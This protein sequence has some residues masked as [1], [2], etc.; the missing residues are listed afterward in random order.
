MTV[1]TQRDARP[2]ALPLAAR[3]LDD[4]PLRLVRSDLNRL[5]G[6]NEL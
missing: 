6:E 4:A 5:V 1:C 2:A 3:L